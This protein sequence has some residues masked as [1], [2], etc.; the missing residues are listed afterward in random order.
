MQ[1]LEAAGLGRLV[2]CKT[3]NTTE[4]FFCKPTPESLAEDHQAL[5]LISVTHE[6]YRKLFYTAETRFCFN[7][8]E[9]YQY[10]LLATKFT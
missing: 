9:H 1:K 7:I 2:T 8:Q 5:Q 10:E 3:N 6:E 4:S